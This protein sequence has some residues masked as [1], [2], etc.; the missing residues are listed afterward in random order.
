MES[1]KLKIFIIVIFAFLIQGCE[2]NTQSKYKD[3]NPKTVKFTKPKIEISPSDK[4]LQKK[5]I[6][7]IK[8]GNIDKLPKDLEIIKYNLISI[9]E[10]KI[11]LLAKNDIILSQE[12]K[13]LKMLINT[14]Y[15][16]YSILSNKKHKGDIID[17][18]LYKDTI[19][20]ASKDGQIKIWNKDNLK[21]IKTLSDTNRGIV[22]LTIS[23]DRLYSATYS[24]VTIYD[25]KEQKR[26][27]SLSTASSIKSLYSLNNI[28]LISTVKNLLI[29]NGKTGKT[30]KTVKQSNDYAFAVNSTKVITSKDSYIYVYNKKNFKLLQKFDTKESSINNMIII[31]NQLITSSKNK[32][33][34][35]NLKNTMQSNHLKPLKYD[36]TSMASYNGNL[37][38]GSKN[39]N[40]YIYNLKNNKFIGNISFNNA[41]YK[42]IIKD[43]FIYLDQKGAISRV[44]LNKL[45]KNLPHINKLISNLHKKT[46]LALKVIENKFKLQNILKHKDK[47]ILLKVYKLTVKRTFK[48]GKI[49]ERYVP[50]TSTSYSTPNTK[51][52]YI[53]GKSYSTTTYSKGG[54][55]SGGNNEKVYG[56]KAIYRIDNNSNKYYHIKL[57]LSWMGKYSS[58]QTYNKGGAWSNESGTGR[59]LVS[60]ESPSSTKQEFIIAPN[61]NFK[62]QFELGE[63]KTTNITIDNLQIEEIPKKYYDIFMYALDIKNE[64]IQLLNKFIDDTKV[65]NWK[66][67]IKSA[68]SDIIYNI[69]K[70]FNLE[71]LKKASVRILFDKK[72][73]DKDFNS[74]VKLE[75]TSNALGMC[76]NIRTPFGTKTLD[77]TTGIQSGLLLWKKYT[78]SKTYSI[79]GYS[80]SSLKVSVKSVAKICN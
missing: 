73:Y 22:D 49:G 65:L 64:D 53:N 37:F 54:Y 55:S 56:Y 31:D 21:F 77:T 58:Y 2:N 20:T 16:K 62:F 52:T 36:I 41:I 70:R 51:Y 78:K 17:I 19:I 42:L 29:V 30:L 18:L 46:Y 4:V 44:N 60:K 63:E 32:I 39:G 11:K 47:N 69:N 48:H 72:K 27:K 57:N 13:D 15:H 24:N 50:Y 38:L 79:K 68:K 45:F 35:W 67:K 33:I 6:T 8:D 34:I 71:N 43:N 76:I 61:D 12:L 66:N 3:F 1:I 26:I 10:S 7:Y 59:R 25:M 28:L 74:N 40:L 14:Q 23:N 80:Q 5:F 9:I 75:A